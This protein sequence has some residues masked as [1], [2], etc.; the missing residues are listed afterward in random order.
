MTDSNNEPSANRAKDS[1]AF[2]KARNKAEEY[3]SDPEK[4]NDLIDKASRKANGSKGPLDAVWTQLMA[5]F[6]LIKAYANGTYRQIPWS[7]LVMLITAVIYFVM[8]IDLIPDFILGL[9]L[10][11]DAAILAWI[12][13]TFSSD[14]EAFSDWESDESDDSE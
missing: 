6:R 2:K 14:I 10:V 3:V 11:D 1:E 13:K 9:G 5:C 12:V 7:S 8:P 4:L